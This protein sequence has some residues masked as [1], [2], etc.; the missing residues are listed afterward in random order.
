MTPKIDAT[1]KFSDYDDEDSAG[2]FML[3]ALDPRLCHSSERPSGYKILP[4]TPV[5]KNKCSLWHSIISKIWR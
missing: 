1:S 5:Q 2:A 3:S 4:A